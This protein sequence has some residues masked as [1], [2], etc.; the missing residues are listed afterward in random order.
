VA[1]L[2]IRALVHKRNYVIVRLPKN[3]ARICSAE[4]ASSFPNGVTVQPLRRTN[5]G[6]FE[7]QARFHATVPVPVLRDSLFVQV[8]RTDTV[9]RFMLICAGPS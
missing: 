8:Q 7:A 3:A 6:D 1:L 5:P 2:L 9:Q 4:T